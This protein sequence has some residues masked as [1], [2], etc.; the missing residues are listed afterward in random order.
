VSIPMAY[1]PGANHG[2]GR[3]TAEAAAKLHGAAEALSV[4][5]R[6][7]PAERQR[8]AEYAAELL[9][10]EV[11]P[12]DWR[13]AGLPTTAQA[14][15]ED[16]VPVSHQAVLHLARTA[17]SLRCSGLHAV[18]RADLWARLAAFFAQLVPPGDPWLVRLREKTLNARINAEDTSRDVVEKLLGTYQLHARANGSE[19]YMTSLARANLAMAYCQRGTGADL[20][21]AMRLCRQEIQTRTD[22]Y[23]ADHPITLVA[24]SLLARCLLAQAEVTEDRGE[25][26]RL[27]HEA[28][29]DADRV[30]VARDRLFGAL[31]VSATLSRRYQG[32][33]LFLLGDL[34]RARACLQHALA[35]DTAR[36]G[37]R[38]WRGSGRTHLL[39]ARVH[40][41][42]GD[43]QAALDDARDAC[44]LLGA[45]TPG[46]PSRWAAEALLRELERG[47][48]S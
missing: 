32:H 31:S 38:E 1:T 24:R 36:N 46:G 9:A 11:Q 5:Q 42:L 27:A 40:R 39:L 13:R 33:A 43:Q 3:E 25:R 44:R 8:A 30:R 26:S 14:G 23:G 10:R 22:R 45:D 37:N 12:A 21:E 7:D 20:A 17:M 19:A 4:L 18:Q 41:A 15:K 35:F 34:E 47:S 29:D 28:F 16:G 6:R 48:A 2:W